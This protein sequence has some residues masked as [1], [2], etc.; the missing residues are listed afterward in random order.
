MM[1]PPLDRCPAWR[2]ERLARGGYATLH[3]CSGDGASRAVKL[4]D[5]P[6]YANVFERE[7]DTLRMMKGC[8]GVP[9]V[10]DWG[11]LADG[12]LCI[13]C[14]V[15]PGIPL[16]AYVE[17][18]GPLSLERAKGVLRQLL[19]ILGHAHAK[20]VLHKAVTPDNILFDGERVELLEW[21][22]G[23]PIGDGRGEEIRGDQRWVAPECYYG[24]HHR[25]GDLYALGWVTLFML[26]G[27][28]PYHMEAVEDQD[29]RM[30][31]HCFE[32]PR[33]PEGVAG[34]IAPLIHAWLRKE[35]ERRPLGYDLEV[36][37]REA[38]G[39][40]EEFFAAKELRQLRHEFS[41]LYYA[42][43]HGVPYAQFR[44][45]ERLLKESGRGR[46][47]L[48]WLNEAR[49][50]GCAKAGYRLARCLMEGVAGNRSPR[51]AFA[52]L[53]AAARGGN[54]KAQFALAEWLLQ[55]PGG[56]HEARHYYGLAADRGEPRARL[57]LERGG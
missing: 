53:R 51:R 38:D 37:S 33:L 4:F 41:F 7:L 49:Q 32:R 43:V 48:F 3:R 54:A 2:S 24:R 44:Y 8:R 14:D 17:R 57:I 25:S 36:V 12:R 40:A 1:I 20:G 5:Q 21:G 42:V 31:A 9:G 45:G 47:A 11:R 56:D 23:E 35:P 26:T 10:V 22:A 39:R 16:T 19:E 55:R 6:G 52:Y 18:E 13:V 28:L 29:Y 30:V 34:E 15:S 46:E 50:A 27:E